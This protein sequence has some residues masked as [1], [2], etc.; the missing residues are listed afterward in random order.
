VIV[1]GTALADVLLRAVTV[2]RN[3]LPVPAWFHSQKIAGA[4]L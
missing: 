2:L 3:K 1:Q 4:D